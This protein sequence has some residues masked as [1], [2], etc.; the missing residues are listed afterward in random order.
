MLSF[1][2][3]FLGIGQLSVDSNVYVA[4]VYVKYPGSVLYTAEAQSLGFP[5]SISL[6][7]ESAAALL[8]PVTRTFVPLHQCAQRLNPEKLECLKDKGEVMFPPVK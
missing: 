3:D 4:H 6:N 8:R 7:R 1:V 5:A 2:T